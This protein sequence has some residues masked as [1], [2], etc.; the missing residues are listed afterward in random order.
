MSVSAGFG[1][2]DPLGWLS[3]AAVGA[4]DA[5]SVQ[6]GVDAR[7]LEARVVQLA[8]WV[9]VSPLGRDS[10]V[11]AGEV[12]GRAGELTEEVVALVMSGER[13]LQDSAYLLSVGRA[14][15]AGVLL[16]GAGLAVTGEVL[17]RAALATVQEQGYPVTRAT[18]PQD[19]FVALWSVMHSDGVVEAWRAALAGA[20]AVGVADVGA[21]STA[22]GAGSVP[23][24]G[25][26]ERGDLGLELLVPVRNAE[27][28]G[29]DGEVDS[30]TA[31]ATMEGLSYAD[32]L[33]ADLPY[34]VDGGYAVQDLSPAAVLVPPGAPESAP[35]GDATA[36][37]APPDSA[38]VIARASKRRR[39]TK[40]RKADDEPI[41]VLHAPRLSAE[42]LQKK[43]RAILAGIRASSKNAS[44]AET[45]RNM[46]MAPR[47]LTNWLLNRAPGLGLGN[48]TTPLKTLRHIR[49]T[50]EQIA[51]AMTGKPADALTP[52][53]AYPELLTELDSQVIGTLLKH[54][55]MNL[56]ALARQYNHHE[57][58]LRFWVQGLGHRLGVNR[59]AADVAVYV[60]QDPARACAAAFLQ[61]GDPLPVIP[62]GEAEPLTELDIQVIG[63][64][65]THPDLHI[66]QLAHQ[67]N[68]SERLLNLWVQSLGGRLGVNRAAADVAVYV[69]QDPARACA[70]A[71][72]QEG[73]PLPVIPV[74]E[75]EP[76]TELD[77][78]VIGTL[79]SHPNLTVVDLGNHYHQSSQ[80]LRT[81]IKDLGRRLRTPDGTAT[82]V[83]RWV[84]KNRATML[85]QFGLQE[86]SLPTI[87][88]GT[89]G[90]A[91]RRRHHSS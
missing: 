14:D 89:H 55:D 48:T 61:E 15:L 32:L 54:P 74:G 5:A 82:G 11:V 85:T 87:S 9:G 56:A 67:Y 60:R 38:P 16:E 23:V 24:A 39:S 90:I 21:G 63:T 66:S 43:D 19:L 7:L 86:D 8:L 6:V 68:H 59:P 44:I 80:T 18:D 62:V 26:V 3:A 84:R 25:G 64:L 58:N 57:V 33:S 49:S 30:S 12:E 88:R 46:E 34:G 45:A 42:Q 17:V 70:A 36:P 65:L 2:G 76:L 71:F 22:A 81:W 10:Q 83:M 35:V 1:V 29:L 28:G 4:W 69:R 72:L 91:P 13:D 47:A 78:R 52:A 50:I 51:P 75:A 20:A 40:P 53:D 37:G 79:L 41:Q 77:I 27:G 31:G 73:D